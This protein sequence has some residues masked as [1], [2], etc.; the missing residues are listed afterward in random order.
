MNTLA[1]IAVKSV[2]SSSVEV[3]EGRVALSR[4][5]LSGGLVLGEVGRLGR[6]WIV[7]SGGSYDDGGDA[8]K[9]EGEEEHN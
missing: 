7:T 1:Y 9:E 6:E 8:E 2:S 3:E 5:R 4:V